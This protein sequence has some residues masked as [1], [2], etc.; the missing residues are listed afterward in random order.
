MFFCFIFVSYILI[1]RLDQV[2]MNRQY[3]ICSNLTLILIFYNLLKYITSYYYYSFTDIHYQLYNIIK[4][5]LYEN[6]NTQYFTQVV[7]IFNRIP[8]YHRILRRRHECS[9][10][11]NFLAVKIVCISHAFPQYEVTKIIRTVIYHILY[12]KGSATTVTVGNAN[13][14]RS[15]LQH[16]I[17]Y[18]YAYDKIVPT[19]NSN[20]SHYHRHR[21]R[22]QSIGNDF[23]L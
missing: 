5:S 17:L 8:I 2:S 7:S 1:I 13:L 21:R 15:H 14:C 20:Q 3:V 18:Y 16:K 12:Y 22:R 19:Y 4:I 10:K 23:L 11:T 9:V 6:N